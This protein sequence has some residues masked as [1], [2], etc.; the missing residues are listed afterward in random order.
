MCYWQADLN[1][2]YRYSADLNDGQ[3]QCVIWCA[4]LKEGQIQCG[5]HSD[6]GTITLLF[7][8]NTG[9]LQVSNITFYS[10]SYLKEDF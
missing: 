3:I 4:D 5:E 6:Y 2:Q 1:S 8:D 9:G 10:S 7:Q